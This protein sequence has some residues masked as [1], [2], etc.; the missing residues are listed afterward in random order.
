M[1]R[2]LLALAM[3]AEVSPRAP[4]LA[5]DYRG[6]GFSTGAPTVGTL[7]PDCEA[8]ATA[9]PGLLQS[10]NLA[11]RPLVVYGRSLGAACAIHIVSLAPV[12][13]GASHP[14]AAARTCTPVSHPTHVFHQGR[15]QTLFSTRREAASCLSRNEHV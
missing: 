5:F 8:V 15:K 14:L 11:G 1:D 12:R 10:K 9:L 7:L 6:Y 4:V 3:S 2:T 13:R